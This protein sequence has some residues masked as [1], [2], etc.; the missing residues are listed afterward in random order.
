M[1]KKFHTFLKSD[2]AVLLDVYSLKAF[3]ARE[4]K[5]IC[6]ANLLDGFWSAELYYGFL[7]IFKYEKEKVVLD[8]YTII[9]AARTRT[10]YN[11]LQYFSPDDLTREFQDG[12]FVVDG[13]YTDVAGSPFTPEGHEFAVVAKKQG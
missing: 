12:G 1:L 7:N 4:E 13:F 9:E 8:Q 11:W 3:D 5:T 10:V 2:G 6:G